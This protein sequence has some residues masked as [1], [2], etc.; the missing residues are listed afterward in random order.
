MGGKI[1]FQQ[2]NF[3]NPRK[4][5]NEDNW[6]GLKREKS[7]KTIIE[8]RN[9]FTGQ[10]EERNKLSVFVKSC[11]FPSSE[12]CRTLLILFIGNAK[13]YNFSLNQ[14]EKGYFELYLIN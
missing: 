8:V 3:K 10:G 9:C 13:S 1:C 4:K 5:R 6:V 12:L 11:G 7:G 14:K 2:L